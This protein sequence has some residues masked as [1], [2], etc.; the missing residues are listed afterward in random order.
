MKV[1]IYARVSTDDKA[2]DPD[3]QLYALREFCMRAEWEVVEEYV[4]RARAKDFKHRIAWALL[5]KDARQRN[6]KV[7]LVFK[8]DRAF[9]SVR[10]CCNQTHE[11]D[12]M[13]IKFVASSQDI[14]TT[15]P[16][17][18]YFLHNLAA[19]AELESSLI[20][21]RVKSGIA[22][23]RAQGN[24]YGRKSKPFSWEAVKAHLDAGNT[25][26]Q[27]ADCLG[28]SRARIYQAIKENENV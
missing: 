6:F 12:A 18:Q 14:D 21:D 8:L 26:T 7:V 11:W 28:Y 17:G 9:R 5:L 15:T 20:S 19:V 22:R 10:E 3:S 24:R 1:A 23:T 2:Q 4:D 13:G 27:T 25:I 16:M